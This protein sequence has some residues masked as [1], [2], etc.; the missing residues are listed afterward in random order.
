MINV[1]LASKLGIL[2]KIYARKTIIKEISSAEMTQFLDK[3]HLQK[4]INA[5]IRIGLFLNSELIEVMT[6]GKPR[7]NKTTEYELLRLCSKAGVQVI[8]GASK[9]FS[10]FV[11]NYNPKT[12]LSYSDRRLGVPAVYTKLGFTLVS[13]SNPGY[14]YWKINQAEKVY[15]IVSR[16]QAQ[17]HKLKNILSNFD[18]TKTEQDNMLE[19]GYGMTYDSGQF[20]FK[21]IN[22]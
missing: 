3:Y 17:K 15:E 12:I 8:G 11:K 2:N 22:Q 1:L 13:I 9:L 5:P 4:S 10:Y 21:W 14:F 20:I 16:Y 18:N 6:F 7:F 19:A